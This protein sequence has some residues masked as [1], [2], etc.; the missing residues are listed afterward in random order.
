MRS[1]FA[2][3][4]L[5]TSLIVALAQSA[6]Q[7][8]QPDLFKTVKPEAT[9]RVHR[10]SLGADLVEITLLDPNYP[11][12]V[13]RSQVQRLGTYLKS[14]PTALNVQY[15]DLGVSPE[16]RYLRATFGIDGLSDPAK[17][18][19]RLGALAKAM[20]GG[21]AGHQIHGIMVIFEGQKPLA[22]T[23]QSYGLAPGSPVS[24]M[25]MYQP[26]PIGLEYR[27]ALNTQDPSKIDIPESMT[28]ASANA[29]VLSPSR[30]EQSVPWLL[31]GSA[32]LFAL[33][34]GALVYSVTLRKSRSRPSR[35]SQ[36]QSTG[37]FRHR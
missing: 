11:P 10:H 1:L 8:A 23:L 6:V 12:E 31:Y 32:V 20:A 28:A 7:P 37:T 27:I 13:L 33:A 17:G 3:W 26:G 18:I 4:L 19:Y 36:K 9:I 34:V 35:V 16:S 14:E 21:P 24:V 15:V 30:P 25:G 22:T 5:L 29:T 2:V